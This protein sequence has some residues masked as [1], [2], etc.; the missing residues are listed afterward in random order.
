[1]PERTP[2]AQR[3]LAGPDAAVHAARRAALVELAQVLSPAAAD[4]AIEQIRAGGG[5]LERDLAD[6][7]ARARAV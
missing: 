7:L 4:R 5:E 3:Q 6:E 1:M 2:A